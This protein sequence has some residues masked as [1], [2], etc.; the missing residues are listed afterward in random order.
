[1]TQVG[2]I[3]V[4]YGNQYINFNTR[5]HSKDKAAVKIFWV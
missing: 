1:M 3:N 2:P 5:F 4:S